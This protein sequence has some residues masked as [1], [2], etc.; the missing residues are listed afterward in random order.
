MVG[1]GTR[2]SAAT[3][4]H[5]RARTKK[6]GRRRAPQRPVARLVDWWKT[7]SRELTLLDYVL[8][9]GFLTLIATIAGVPRIPFQD[10]PNHHFLLTLDRALRLAAELENYRKRVARQREE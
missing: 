3:G 2:M 9:A 7:S 5:R 8:V 1:A 6:G 10:F 4:R